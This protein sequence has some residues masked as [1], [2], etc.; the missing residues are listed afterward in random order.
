MLRS[1]TKDEMQRMNSAP[2]P[3]T[4]RF[5]SGDVA[6]LHGDLAYTGAVFQAASQ[7]NCLEFF[8]KTYTPELGVAIY[9]NDP[10]QGP[11][12]AI[13]CAPGTIVRNYFAF[14][15]GTRP[16]TK[17]NQINTLSGVNAALK[18]AAYGGAAKAQRVLVD[19]EN[20]YTDS[21]S[22]RL[23]TLN[24]TIAGLTSA[25]LRS[26]MANLQVGVQRNTQ[27]TCTKPQQKGHWRRVNATQPVLVT[28]VYASAIPVN[29]S[30]VTAG[31]KDDWRRLAELVLEAAY[32]ATLHAAVRQ[33]ME[34]AKAGETGRQ[35]VVLTALGYYAF[36]NPI[37][38]VSSAIVRALK[39]FRDAGLDVVINESV[40]GDLGYIKDA[41]AADE[42]T[43]QLLPHVAP[44]FGPR[45]RPVVMYTE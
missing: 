3:T 26:L 42:E 28:Q 37:E 30:Y 25:K 16:Q 43:S 8:A 32:E 10:T 31:S 40:A 14:H 5:V 41:I 27:V 12:C 6:V 45:V 38:W 19:V 13:S 23:R 22:E 34:K 11:A 24:Q 17:S 4:V 33:A 44:A 9:A 29:T 21:D 2:S 35:K 39:I 18:D 36:A 20:G 7:F 15:N 1:Q